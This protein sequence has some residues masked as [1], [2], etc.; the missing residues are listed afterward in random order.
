MNDF[1]QQCRREWKRLRVP[2]P[3]ANEMAADL[4]ADLKEAEA[5]G[6]SEEELL[7]TSAFD[8]CSFAAAWAAERGVI[9]SAP[10]QDSASRKP[11]IF[12]A[13]ATLTVIGLIVTAWIA[14]PLR[15]GSVAMAPAPPHARLPLAPPAPSGLFVRHGRPLAVDGLAWILLLVIAVL[16]VFVTARLWSRWVHTRPPTAPA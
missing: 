15:S 9:P 2:D 12:A 7:G 13:L 5:E 10:H 4:A 3:V 6:V 11:L 14:L 1:V 16:A 8:P